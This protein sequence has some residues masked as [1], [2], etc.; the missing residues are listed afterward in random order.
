[1]FGAGIKTISGTDL[2]AGIYY[3]SSF[4]D[5]LLVYAWNVP[6]FLKNGSQWNYIKNGAGKVIGIEILIG[7]DDTD[8]FTIFPNPSCSGT[9]VATLPDTI[10]ERVP[11]TG[12]IDGDDP[13]VLPWT[14]E[15]IA[16][17]GPFGNFTVWGDDG[18]GFYQPIDSQPVPDDRDNPTT[19]T[20][21]GL[22][23]IKYFIVIG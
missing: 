3:N 10:N 2:V 17:Y 8:Q 7:F 9:P 21:A 6:N 16:K 4:V 20:F 15:R 1:M 12:Y 14:P 23:G 13:Y 11:L 18:S 22:T 19:F 5:D